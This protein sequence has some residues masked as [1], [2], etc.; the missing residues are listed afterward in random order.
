[1]E[2]KAT[3]EDRQEERER[4]RELER[5]KNGGKV[6]ESF[7]RKK[8]E[9]ELEKERSIRERGKGVRE[10]EVGGMKRERRGE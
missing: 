7:R 9:G 6:F 1:M 5:E 3:V 10:G 4:K 2:R 8:R